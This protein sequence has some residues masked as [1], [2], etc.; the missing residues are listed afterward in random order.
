[1]LS[2]YERHSATS[3]IGQAHPARDDAGAIAMSPDKGSQEFQ[4]AMAAD[5][6][7]GGPGIS[8]KLLRTSAAGS[9][10]FVYGALRDLFS[11]DRGISFDSGCG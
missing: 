10:S 7:H 11:C 1:M 2:T 6:C 8:P 4:V 3:G 9:L 5:T